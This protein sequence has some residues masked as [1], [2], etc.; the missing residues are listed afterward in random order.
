MLD[1]QIWLEVE[2]IVNVQHALLIIYHVKAQFL[3]LNFMS[4][5]YLLIPLLRPDNILHIEIK[6]MKIYQYLVEKI[7]SEI[8]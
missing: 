3:T 4:F 6:N 8:K 5:D 1:W 7:I 2:E